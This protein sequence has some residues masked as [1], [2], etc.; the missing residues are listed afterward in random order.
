[1]N[2]FWLRLLKGRLR[3]GGSNH[4][5]TSS[6]VALRQLRLSFRSGLN[7]V[8][9]IGLSVLVVAAVVA[10]GLPQTH[11]STNDGGVWITS[12][13]E[14]M[15]AR[16]VAPIAEVDTGFGP[17]GG[18]ES[19]YRLNVLQQG[20]TVV[21]EDLAKGYAYPVN[22][23]QGT[24][25][26]NGVALPGGADAQVRLGGPVM[27]VL[28]RGNGDVW[29]AD[30]A[31]GSG[32]VFSPEEFSGK[33]LLKIKGAKAIAVSQSGTV[34][35]ATPKKL[36]TL[37]FD[38]SGFARP[39]AI[40]FSQS[41]VGDLQLSVV[42]T[43]PV[44]LETAR[45][46][47]I[48]PDT[49]QSFEVPSDSSTE[50]TALQQSGPSSSDAFVATTHG[51]YGV[52]LGGGS[53]VS[54]ESV[55]QGEPAAPVYLDGCVYGAWSGYPGQLVRTCS[56]GIPTKTLLSGSA[57]ESP[58]FRVN[59][60]TVLLNDEVT[61]DAW[62]VIK[63]PRLVIAKKN[64]QLLNQSQKGSTQNLQRAALV[65]TSSEKPIAHN[66]TTEAHPGSI[67]V[68]HLLDYTSNPLGGPLS[69]DSISPVVGPGYQAEIS[70]DTQTV[71]LHLDS[72]DSAPIHFAYTVINSKG[73]T[74][75]AAVTV[76]PTSAS[77][78]PYLRLGF[79][80][81]RYAIASTASA[82]Y[83]VLSGWRDA[84][85]DPLALLNAT[86]TQGT[87]SW[88]GTGLVTLTAPTETADTPATISYV[89]TN[90]VHRATGVVHVQILGAGTTQAVAPIA[91]PNIVQATVGQAVTLDPLENNIPGADPLHPDAQLALAGPLVAP[92]GLTVSTD[93]S[94]E[95]V[96][97]NP[98]R[99]G[100][101]TV[102]YQVAFGSAPLASSEILVIARSPVASAN[103]PITT[104]ASLLLHGNQ[105]A[106]IDVLAGDYDPAG[107]LLT[108]I[109][110][111]TPSGL[112]VAVVQGKW[113]RIQS[114]AGAFSGWRLVTYQVTNGL[115]PPATG[116]VAVAWT[117]LGS[118]SPPI[119][120][121]M[122]TQVLAGAY[123]D[124]RAL[125]N[126]IDP[127]GG[128]MELV[129]GLVHVSPAGEGSASV[130]G[131]ILRYAAPTA[132]SKGAPKV[133]SVSYVVEDEFGEE[134]TG[135]VR[136]TVLPD[137][138]V[139]P[140]PP[141]PPNVDVRVVAGEQVT[142]PIPNTGIDSN[143][144]PASSIGIVTA[145][146]LGRIVSANATSITYQAYP[147]V[148]GTDTFS[149]EME[150]SS[151]QQGTGTI[152]VGIVPPQVLAP[153]TATPLF[154]TGAPGAKLVV[155]LIAWV[156]APP[157]AKVAISPL[158]ATNTSIPRGTVLRGS[159]LYVSAPANGHSFTVNYGATD[160]VGGMTI[161]TVTIS[162][163]SGYRLPPFAADYFPSLPTDGAKTVDVNVLAKSYVIGGGSGGLHLIR[164]FGSHASIRGNGVQ[165]ALEPLPRE[166]AYEIADLSGATAVGV[167]HLPGLDTG[168]SALSSQ[169]MI[170]VPLGGNKV[171]NIDSYIKDSLGSV[172]LVSDSG[173]A[174]SPVAGLASHP[175]SYTSVELADV[176]RYDG[177][178]ALVVQVTPKSK[179]STTAI[180]GDFISVPVQVGPAEPILSCPTAPLQ[181]DQGGTPVSLSVTS[182]CV[183]WVPAGMDPAKLT[184]NV[185]WSRSLA[186]VGLNTSDDGHTVE[187]VP[188]SS[189]RNGL[190]G[191]VN[192]AIAG[193]TARSQINVSE[194]PA[195]LATMEHITI[196]GVTD[197]QTV[198]VNVGQSVLS[199]LLHPSIKVLS[200]AE[201]SGSPAKVSIS[202]QDVL[203][204]PPKG[205]VGI[206]N[207]SVAVTDVASEPISRRITGTVTLQLLAAPT[208]PGRIQGTPGNQ[209]VSLSWAAAQTNGSLI[210]YYQLSDGSQT[211]TVPGTNYTWTGLQNGQTYGF[212]VR[213]HNSQG[214]GPSTA[215]TD[216]MPQAIPGP[217]GAIQAIP[218]N[219]QVSLQWGAANSNGDAVSYQVSVSPAPTSGAGSTVVTGTSYT[220]SGLNNAIG[221][222]TFT[223]TPINKL[224]P[225]PSVSSMPVYSFGVPSAPAAPSASGAVSPDQTTTTITVS[226][227]VTANC[228]DA[229]PCSSYTLL[230]YRDGS[231]ADTIPSAGTLCSTGVGEFCQT[232]G[233]L[234]NDGATYA[235]FLKQVNSEG[236][237]SSA[238]PESSPGVQ[239]VGIPGAV[240]NLS[241]TP[242]NGGLT[243]SFTL[244]PSHGSGISGVQ[245]V[246]NGSLSGTWQNPGN[247]GSSISETIGGL[248]PGDL[249]TLTVE[250]CNEAQE[251]GGSSNAASGMPYGPPNP[252]SVGANP[253]GD[254]ITFYWSGGGGN[255]STVSRYS[256]TI[257]GSSTNYSSPGSATNSYSC[258]TS[259]TISATDTN[260]A[261][262]T[263][264]SV[265]AT[266]TTA[267]CPLPP[268]PPPSTTY[269][270]TVGG[271]THTWTD[272][273]N[274]GG[275][276]GA[277]ISN[278][279]TVQVS[280]RVQGFAVADGDTWWYRIASSPW[281]DT[282]YASA[283]AF[284][285]NGQTS[286]SLVGT[287]FV[288]TNVPTC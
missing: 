265:A 57:L 222:Y 273:M 280:C 136:V 27:A 220:W 11:V 169:G 69:I 67:A 286:G 276:E 35:V 228:N 154:A 227:P 172:R 110:S 173:V 77:T 85:N 46:A 114:T 274:A 266:A 283:D 207:F 171:V 218:G 21:V 51:L 145:P 78:A 210:D 272:Y 135:Q 224:G 193:T 223:V 48:L 247:S 152:R 182:F 58:V 94:T 87:V 251:C 158:T 10:P 160:G 97:I 267:A 60:G 126:A 31:T 29:A 257:G 255:G 192:I 112:S 9:A 279:T 231:L 3:S 117:S 132:L 177:P 75:T 167:I 203:I 201:V 102:L 49:N 200:A 22:V 119:V 181:V 84:Q 268:S 131:G 150:N 194:V 162:G 50:P 216:L 174:S 197:G 89:L 62:A 179:A 133:L 103:T 202:G 42:G 53:M 33:P 209:Q 106:T 80:A 141:S 166:I 256:V 61:G 121:L 277:T 187:L 13:A 183:L 281:N 15:F 28:D 122:S 64:Y 258:G 88:T 232:I 262:Q 98:S 73:F 249:Y 211:I 100:I 92:S 240:T 239:A 12:N 81:R 269:A 17:P 54:I 250:A 109:S 137:T 238:S 72:G 68:L 6:L 241:V 129:P 205:S 43:T 184:F 55:S 108:V 63:H 120:P 180:A 115:G 86:T 139:P 188:G 245:Y 236:K 74:A 25:S 125:D 199:P 34:Y 147:D 124:L 165:A 70:L 39:T 253:N 175:V 275:N 18:F 23:V 252:P 36:W 230:E 52:P 59:N 243:A 5:R 212:S 219:G 260:A 101:F 95:T 32:S 170:D 237:S 83:Q 282:Y 149:Y 161:S 66:V 204:T 221:P 130:V 144:E 278:G 261:G 263:S 244:P 105:P 16:Y 155:N 242:T 7:A 111:S 186:G 214:F 8:I 146:Q 30:I 82:T 264:S 156:I 142:I 176:G 90:G 185:S 93:M 190:G 127:M 248:T 229:R 235:F 254:S 285:N 198:T 47:V 40:S 287:P 71:S 246:L 96:S 2:A 65:D 213:A 189:Y 20:T 225:G 41:L 288:D 4:R 38:G 79:I 140:T 113:L 163:Q 99:A 215:V 138:H 143:G 157:Q 104:P 91:Q 178:G 159:D 107:G 24:V 44:I 56:G 26:T 191:V 45:L 270:E 1:M 128:S 118:I 195:P 164:I 134:T 234:S 217:P 19:S 151:G 233:P 259:I 76:T 14:A 284:Y 271:N 123:V 148:A 196:S 153:A 37:Y 116:L 168:A 206:Q 226:W 208:S